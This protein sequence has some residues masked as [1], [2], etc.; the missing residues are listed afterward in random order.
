MYYTKKLKVV[1]RRKHLLTNTCCCSSHRKEIYR[2]MNLAPESTPKSQAKFHSKFLLAYSIVNILIFPLCVGLEVIIV[3]SVELYFLKSLATV[4]TFW[5]HK[6]IHFIFKDRESTRR[7]RCLGIDHVYFDGI[8]WLQHFIQ[9]EK[10]TVS[11]NCHFTTKTKE[12]INVRQLLKKIFCVGIQDYF[13]CGFLGF[14]DLFCC[15]FCK[16]HHQWRL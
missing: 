5:L 2:K 11:C 7:P 3:F 10:F 6:I 8:T 14:L 12:T 16:Y 13:D 9:A 4:S 1:I 15:H